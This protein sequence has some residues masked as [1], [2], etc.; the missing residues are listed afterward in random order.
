MNTQATP[1]TTAKF[2]SQIALILKQF[3]P[4]LV[5]RNAF[6]TDVLG[7]GV[8]IG[9]V[10]FVGLR[11]PDGIIEG[12]WRDDRVPGGQIGSSGRCAQEARVDGCADEA[13]EI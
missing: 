12:E 13:H 9:I 4:D 1:Y 5:E 2:K 10:T 11:R 8:A 6:Y 7:S 3:G